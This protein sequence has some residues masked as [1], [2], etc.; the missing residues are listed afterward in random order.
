MVTG[1]LV[2]VDG[3]ATRSAAVGWRWVVEARFGGVP[4]AVPGLCGAVS[5]ASIAGAAGE[6]LAHLVGSLAVDEPTIQRL[7]RSGGS[8]G[9]HR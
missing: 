8:R 4:V 9:A 6:Q 2:G 3:P 5:G 1:C 7:D